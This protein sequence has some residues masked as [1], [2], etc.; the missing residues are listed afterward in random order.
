MSI[1]SLWQWNVVAASLD[2][3][4]A[5]CGEVDR[6]ENRYG[7]SVIRKKDS[8]G[9]WIDTNNSTNDFESDAPASLLQK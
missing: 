9:K 8:D 7:K 2:A 4:W 6:D 5:H 3:G 1:K